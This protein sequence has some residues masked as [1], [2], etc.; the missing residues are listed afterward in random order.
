M[1]GG[2][3]NSTELKLSIQKN[4]KASEKQTWKLQM[5]TAET[6]QNWMVSSKVAVW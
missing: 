2:L 1:R 4:N 5:L 6:K 3:T